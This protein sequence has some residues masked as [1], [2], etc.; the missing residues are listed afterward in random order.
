MLP[1]R[2]RMCSNLCVRALSP[3]NHS[4][5]QTAVWGVSDGMSLC[6]CSC[7]LPLTCR[8][9]SA[10]DSWRSSLAP[11]SVMFS[12]PRAPTPFPRVHKWSLVTRCA[13]RRSGWTTTRRSFTVVTSKLHSWRKMYV[14][15][16]TLK[17]LS[18]CRAATNVYFQCPFIFP[19]LCAFYSA[20]S[21][22]AFGTD[23]L[24]MLGFHSSSLKGAICKTF[25]KNTSKSFV[26]KCEEI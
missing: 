14:Y 18:Q 23:D 9:G 22:H 26:T 10:A 2:F 19:S 16:L 4:S 24:V 17:H 25:F 8:C 7:C 1:F 12:A 5:I 21:K 20:C 13:W 15:L 3:V 6:I 11:L